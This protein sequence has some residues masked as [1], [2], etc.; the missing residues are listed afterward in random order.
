MKLVL[1]RRAVRVRRDG[2]T[3]GVVIG[4]IGTASCLSPRDAVRVSR[5]YRVQATIT[6]AVVGR[7]YVGG[8]FVA[9]Q[10]RGRWTEASIPNAR[11]LAAGCRPRTSTWRL[12]AYR[13]GS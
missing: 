3:Y 4:S 5:A 11:G 12:D 8:A 2:G 6:W 9:T 1:D 7:R 13:V 10:L